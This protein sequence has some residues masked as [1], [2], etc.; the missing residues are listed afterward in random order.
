MDTLTITDVLMARAAIRPHL[1]PTALHSYPAL[2]AL[3]GAD[4]YV[5]HENHTPIGSFKVRGALNALTA[6]RGKGTTVAACMC[7]FNRVAVR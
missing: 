1:A 2:N 4:V 5:K 7:P 3:V 6:N